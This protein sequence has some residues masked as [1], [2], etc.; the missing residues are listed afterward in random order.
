MVGTMKGLNIKMLA[1]KVIFL[2]I[3]IFLL[4]IYSIYYI[5]YQCAVK[6][7]SPVKLTYKQFKQLFVIAPQKYG[8]KFNFICNYF[9]YNQEH[10]KLIPI[11]F[12]YF[13]LLLVT[14]YYEDFNSKK[15]KETIKE[16]S[17]NNLKIFIEYTQADIDKYLIQTEEYINKAK[18]TLSNLKL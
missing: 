17:N 4:I 16:E 14:F 13:N 15:E 18:D 7:K 9:V 1:V 6:D 8:K 5:F 10:S 11:T 12:N 3:F 2:I